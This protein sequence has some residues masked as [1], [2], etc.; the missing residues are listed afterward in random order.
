MGDPRQ[1]NFKS[2]DFDMY[3]ACSVTYMNEVTNLVTAP[4]VKD[5][6]KTRQRKTN[7]ACKAWIVPDVLCSALRVI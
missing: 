7:A 4:T 3:I 6:H 5:D 2:T 1:T